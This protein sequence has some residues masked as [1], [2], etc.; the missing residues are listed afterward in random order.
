MKGKKLLAGIMSAAMVLGTMALPVFAD[1]ETTAGTFSELKTVIANATAGDTIKLT[2][3][4]SKEAYDRD[5]EF[6]PKVALTF[7]LDGHTLSLNGDNLFSSD[8]TF[9]NGTIEVGPQT[10]TGFIWMWDSAKLVLDEI[11]LNADGV[12]GYSIIDL[13][14]NSDAEIKNSAMNITNKNKSDSSTC[15]NIITDGKNVSIEN[16]E[17]TA[18]NVHRGFVSIS[19]LIIDDKSSVSMNDNTNAAFKNCGGV[20][21]GKITVSNCTSAIENKYGKELT[22]AKNAVVDVKSCTK[23]SIVTG[24]DAVIIVASNNVTTD[25]DISSVTKKAVA[26]IGDKYFTTLQAAIKATKDMPENDITIDCVAGADLGNLVH[27]GVTKNLTINGNGAYISSG[28]GDLSFDMNT[29]DATNNGDCTLTQNIKVVVNN[30]KG[31]GAWGWR[32][33]DFTIDLEFNN[34]EDMFEVYI[35]GEKGTNNYKINNCSFDGTT[36]ASRTT[37]FT[38]TKGTIEIENTK[39]DN[40]IEP[41][42]VNN[43]LTDELNVAVKDSTFTNCS[44]TDGTYEKWESERAPIGII[45]SGKGATV[46]LTV[47]GCEFVYNNSNTPA[48]GQ[49][50][51]GTGETGKTSNLATATI[52]NNNADVIVDVLYPNGTAAVKKKIPANETAIISNVVTAW[53]TLTDSGFYEADGKKYGVMR[54]SFRVNPSLTDITEAG[55][56]FSKA[57][58]PTAEVSG[59]VVSKEGAINVFYGDVTNIGAGDTNNCYAI[60]YIKTAAGKVWSEVVKCSV[61]WNKRFTGYTPGGAE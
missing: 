43:K 9:K 53:D 61:N 3:D 56:K 24:A 58:N 57:E 48:N 38:N 25:D 8:V 17:I 36:K 23:G 51:V 15:S 44:V 35:G 46:N 21:D 32:N 26:S 49:V 31:I 37:V 54:F 33:S 39:F 4:I 41:I 7:D 18:S 14:G 59:T 45:S 42:K 10:S 55:I 52:K 1:G 6:E 30:V 27:A 29:H 28:D 19:N 11:T 20:I 2:A 12:T 50:R 13:N 47:D 40:I 34:C 22:I 5:L 16:T 60:A